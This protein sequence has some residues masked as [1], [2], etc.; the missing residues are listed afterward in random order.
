M[1]L[2]VLWTLL[3]GLCAAEAGLLG[4][5]CDWTGSGLTL[6][7]ERGVTPVYLRCQEG[8]VWWLYPR[9]ALR[10]SFQPPLTE[11][12]FKV[13]IRVIRRPD[14]PDLFHTLDRN[15]TQPESFPARI[16][17]ENKHR[18]VPL[19]AHDDGDPRELRCFRSR[20]G[21]AALYVEADPE[22]GVNRR[23]AMFK[24]E[25][26]PLE[27]K[28]YDPATADC[29]PCSDEQLELAFCTSDLVSRGLFVGSEQ[30]EDLDST[31]LTLKLTKLIRATASDDR[32]DGFGDGDENEEY[33]RYE[34]DNAIEQTTHRNHRRRKGRSLHAHIHVSSICGASTGAGEF[35]VTARRRL[36][37]YALVCSPRIEDWIK[38]V[39]RR[40]EE[41]TAL[42]Q[43]QH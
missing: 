26:R 10:L 38:L 27:K 42:C 3:A 22:E 33:Y 9:G 25:V 19:Y 7:S 6:S 32:Y 41:G 35:L 11:R 36:G 12:D 23:V 13:C 2:G 1:W 40:N 39:K 31:Q 30:R 16:F 5:D 43:L 29:R 28:H 37:R 20:R 8:T 17:V 4:D 18:L 24:Y 21:G 14:P 34:I 15:D